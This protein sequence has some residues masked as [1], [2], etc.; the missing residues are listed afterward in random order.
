[1]SNVLPPADPSASILG[2]S[3][4]FNTAGGLFIPLDD[5]IFVTSVV[6]PVKITRTP[7]WLERVFRVQNAAVLRRINER[8]ADL[9]QRNA[10]S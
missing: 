6:G 10:R 7:G 4:I 1:M 9:R 3:P 2:T 5:E 8:L